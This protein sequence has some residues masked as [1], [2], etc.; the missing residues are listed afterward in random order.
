MFLN[1][2]VLELNYLPKMIP[3][4]EG[5]CKEIAKCIEPLLNGICGKNILVFGRPGIGKTVVVKHIFEE[6]EIPAAYI[7]CWKSNTPHKL[8]MDICEQIGCKW[9]HDKNTDELLKEIVGLTKEGVV[10][11]FDEIDK[12]VDYSILYSLL[13]DINKKAVIAITNERE[14]LVKLDPRVKSRLMFEVLEFRPYKFDECYGILKERV[15][16]AFNKNC[17]SDE[18]LR[19]IAEKSFEAEDIRMGLALLK[20]CGELADSERIEEKHVELTTK[21]MVLVDSKD[22]T[23]NDNDLALIKLLEELNCE[24][25]MG[26][27]FDMY[28][29]RFNESYK[30]LQRRIRRLAGA[31]KIITKRVVTNR[32]GKM[33]LVRLPP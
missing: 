9:V 11:C 33:L 25:S 22:T 7:N 2:E 4:R 31:G 16:Y 12:L 1:P 13:E 26:E 10:F 27:L 15:R 29:G 8:I 30:T 19:L 32:G 6:L 21:R 5:E 23:L 20:S 17:V 18:A 14:Y 28:K 24:K 3:Y